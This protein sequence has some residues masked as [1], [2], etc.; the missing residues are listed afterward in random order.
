[1]QGRLSATT[2]SVVLALASSGIARA[3]APY[4]PNCSVTSNFV[5]VVGQN[6]GVVDTTRTF[7]VTLRDINNQPVAD[8]PVRLSFGG[9]DEKICKD[10]LTS[11]E[12]TIWY[13]CPCRI[14]TKN[15]DSQGNAAFQVLGH[16][17]SSYCSGPGVGANSCSVQYLNLGY[18]TF[19]FASVAILDLDGGGMGPSDESQVLSD[20]FATCDPNHAYV[21]RTDYNGNGANDSGDLSVWLTYFFRG[22]S[23]GAGCQTND[24]F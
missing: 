5:F 14:V 12:T 7:V 2:I 11:G 15:T 22:G 9:G 4:G 18:Q 13:A 16:G 24:D 1:M 20:I 21:A 3:Q 10:Q 6:S 23:A 17:L 8:S 19:A